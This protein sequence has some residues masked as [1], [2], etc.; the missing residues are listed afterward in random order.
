MTDPYYSLADS[1]GVIPSEVNS[2]DRVYQLVK[3]FIEGVQVPYISISISQS[4]GELPNCTLQIPPT[5]GLMDISKYYQPKVHIFFT[6]QNLGGERVLF[7]GHI[8]S[9]SYYK[10]KSGPGQ[11]SITLQCIH[12]NALIRQLTM[13]WM[14]PINST[15]DNNPDSIAVNLGGGT[16]ALNSTES[17]ARALQG[18]TGLA[19]NENVMKP[20]VSPDII[21]K[22]DISKLQPE[23]EEIEKRLTGMS[24]VVINLWNQVKKMIY[25][26]PK[27]NLALFGT[28][29]P[30]LETGLEFFN[31]T[32]GHYF[33][34][35]QIQNSRVDLCP[36]LNKGGDKVLL[37]PAFRNYA[38][39]AIQSSIT[40]Q[41]IQ[42]RVGFSGETSDFHRLLSDLYSAIEYE[43]L[44][45]AS[46][47]E[48][49]V[50]PEVSLDY[51]ADKGSLC[52]IDTI[53]KPQLPFYFSPI[54]NVLHPRLIL[55]VSV[56]QDNLSVPTRVTAQHS[57]LGKVGQG[58]A[59]DLPVNYRAPH[60]Y[61]EATA[62]G[63]ALAMDK[64]VP[65]YSLS[66]T[67][68]TTANV[69]SKFEQGSGVRHT[70]VALPPWL[71]ALIANQAQMG[72][73]EQWPD[74]DSLEYM[75]LLNSSAC[76]KDRYGYKIS[77]DQSG[78]YQK[79]AIPDSKRLP[80]NPFSKDSNIQ[81]YQRIMFSAVDYE[82]AKLVARSRQAVV[83][84]VF[85]PYIVPGYPM[86]VI[87]NSPNAPSFHGMCASVTHS[88]TARSIGTT[89]TMVA[90]QTYSELSN[91]SLPPLH[92]WMQ[93]SLGMVSTLNLSTTSQDYG[94]TSKITDVKYSLIDNAGA[95]EIA[96]QFYREVLGVGAAAPDQLIDFASG[97]AIP[98]GRDYNSTEIFTSMNG[99]TSG[100][101]NN[102]GESNDYLSTV[103][104]LR[105]VARPIESREFMEVTNGLV[106]IDLSPENYSGAATPYS[107]PSL[108]TPFQYEPGQSLFLDYQENEEFLNG[109]K[110]Q[111]GLPVSTTQR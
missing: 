5:P 19:Q 71:A 41:S 63:I 73:E 98:C 44:T 58:E 93:T 109:I 87:D 27:N 69:I 74:K 80:L 4:I 105:L 89:V 14:P 90:A 29:V 42:N 36:D 92:P 34:E 70:R 47:A 78:K 31:R 3:V 54:C 1:G 12:R 104:N 67:T 51:T 2:T 6:D 48:I 107:D 26:N 56:Q 32:S 94:D 85:N 38:Q 40:V 28:W 64:E 20:G 16:L 96:H 17:V 39:S 95:L 100:S 91:Y 101:T 9:S 25:L 59:Q 35:S 33:L 46:P 86:D 72:S 45:L 77:R 68:G 97:Q 8:A 102:G 50:D 88:I 110:K 43:L 65:S 49:P 75:D 57:A 82:Y 55:S 7:N 24:G 11:A 18:I 22:V 84:C 30:L 62:I 60:S 15:T 37:P 103:G 111:L 61:R 13:D 66:D 83:E 79:S 108:S 99:V 21:A 106:F 76:W 81:A 53:I 10:T 23:F 52:A